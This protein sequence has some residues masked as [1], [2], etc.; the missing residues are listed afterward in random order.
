MNVEQILQLLQLIIQILDKLA[1]IGVN[2]SDIKLHTS[3]PLD[4][5]TLFKQN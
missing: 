4:L 3:S 1:A 5:M 2:V